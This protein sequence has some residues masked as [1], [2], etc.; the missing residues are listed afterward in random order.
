MN[1][2]GSTSAPD[3]P[4][5]QSAAD[6]AGG[7]PSSGPAFSGQSKPEHRREARRTASGPIVVRFGQEQA[8]EIQGHLLDVSP[9]GFRMLHQCT[10]LETG[11]MVEFSHPEA[12]GTARVVWNRI[13]DR[14]VETGFFVVQP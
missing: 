11:Q 4:T 5:A 3:R 13:V 14:M 1:R 12:S 9:S 6:A 2:S 7:K 10:T 8:F